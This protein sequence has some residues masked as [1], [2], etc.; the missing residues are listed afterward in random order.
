MCDIDAWPDMT[1]LCFALAFQTLETVF[2]LL[3]FCQVLTFGCS[4]AVFLFDLSLT[5]SNLLKYS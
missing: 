4:T 5:F 2:C 3:R 1:C